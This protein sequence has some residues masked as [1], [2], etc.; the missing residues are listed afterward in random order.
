MDNTQA[1]PAPHYQAHDPV[2]GC[3]VCELPEDEKG[4]GECGDPELLEGLPV[5][6]GC[7]VEVWGVPPA[8]PGP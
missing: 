7:H 6:A 5:C 8:R 1:M 2:P 4:I 3:P